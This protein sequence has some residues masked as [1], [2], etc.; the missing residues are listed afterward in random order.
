MIKGRTV[1]SEPNIPAELEP[2]RDAVALLTDRQ[3]ECMALVAENLN[4][5]KIGKQLGIAPN[6]V[7]K[8]V[9]AVRA[10]FSDMD[11]FDVARIIRAVDEAAA[12]AAA[13]SP[14]QNLGSQ[15]IGLSP[16]PVIAPSGPTNNDAD[17]QSEPDRSITMGK[18][19]QLLTSEMPALL[20]LLP[21]RSSRR[22]SNDLNRYYLVIAF[23][24]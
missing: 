19:V 13:G 10:M 20:N 24:F 17:G 9:K 16:P 14:P 23:A 12:A 5:K 7:D 3:R 22:Q 6:T 11:R 1:V 8:H 18:R 2:Y 21:L 15:S 4:S